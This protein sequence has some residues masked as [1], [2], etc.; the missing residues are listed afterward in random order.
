LVEL[1]EEVQHARRAFL[2]EMAHRRESFAWRYRKAF[3]EF[4]HRPNYRPE[5]PPESV[6]LVQ[7][8]TRE[9]LQELKG[10]LSAALDAGWKP[11]PSLDMRAALQACYYAENHTENPYSDLEAHARAAF[12]D[13][14]LS[15]QRTDQDRHSYE[16]NSAHTRAYESVLSDLELRA[17]SKYGSY[18]RVANNEEFRKRVLKAVYQHFDTSS[19]PVFMRDVAQLLGVVADEENLRVIDKTLKY[20]KE[21]DAVRAV[22]SDSID[23]DWN[24]VAVTGMT[25]I[26]TDIVENIGN[27][28]PAVHFHAPVGIVGNVNARA[29]VN[30]NIGQQFTIVGAALAEVRK[31]LE[32]IP[33][34]ERKEV[35][36]Q[37]EAVDEELATDS[38]RVGRVAL[39]LKA[40]Q[41]ILTPLAKWSGKEVLQSAIQE[42]I[43][44]LL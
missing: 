28:A 27:Q 36:E 1:P 13:V 38:P 24:N 26:G 3:D 19:T 34:N 15:S 7:E 40:I 44:H 39:G 23:H 31:N 11:S 37:A 33:D 42:G 21:K 43:H 35:E 20:W 18:R 9:R 25:S 16:L 30:Q 10:R 14:G 2:A 5:W 22:E 12:A 6:R 32:F 17:T 8:E 29:V 4:C 41:R